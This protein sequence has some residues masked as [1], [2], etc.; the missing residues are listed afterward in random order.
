MNRIPDFF[1]AK[2]KFN[3]MFNL[4]WFQFSMP[5][6]SMRRSSTMDLESASLDKIR[7]ECESASSIPPENSGY[8]HSS[9]PSA[10]GPGLDSDF[11]ASAGQYDAID[12]HLSGGQFLNSAGCSCRRVS[13]YPFYGQ[14]WFSRLGLGIRSGV[15]L[16]RPKL[17]HSEPRSQTQTP[18]SPYHNQ[19]V[20]GLESV[21]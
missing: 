11:G 5:M 12:L 14:R 16:L 18:R 17:R 2:R 6:V 1:N 21:P 19:T 9:S 13:A 10:G 8:V 4:L 3:P 20:L 15:G 7:V